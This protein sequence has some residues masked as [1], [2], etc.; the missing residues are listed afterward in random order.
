MMRHVLRTLK[1]KDLQHGDDE[2]AKTDW[3]DPASALGVVGRD[4]AW[5]DDGQLGVKHRH[6][7]S[8]QI[9]VVEGMYM[10]TM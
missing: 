1:A 2:A 4:D 10:K 8:T 7:K 6:E 3:R 9:L 5:G